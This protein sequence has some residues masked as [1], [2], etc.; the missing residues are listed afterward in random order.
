M[1][2]TKRKLFFASLQESITNCRTFQ[3]LKKTCATHYGAVCAVTLPFARQFISS[4]PGI[5]VDK[6]SLALLPQ[7]AP[8]GHLPVSIVGDGNCF[9]RTLS[10]LAYGHEGCHVE[11]RGRIT[12]EMALN[13]D[14]YLSPDFLSQGSS[15]DG[16]M[17][18]AS[19]QRFAE[20]PFHSLQ[21]A[22]STLEEE[23]FRARELGKYCGMWHMYAAASVLGT[24]IHSIFPNK[25]PSEIRHLTKRTILPKEL[26]YGTSP[27]HTIM[28][29][30][31][32][33]GQSDEYWSPNHFVPLLP[34]HP[35]N[36]EGPSIVRE[37]DE[38]VEDMD[39][40]NTAFTCLEE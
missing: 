13:T 9:P 31:H 22:K 8:D 11:M 12:M 30:S 38:E 10:L 14:Q 20:T 2:D 27:G 17:L 28:W 16:N 40:F 23:L 35:P 1:D 34:L 39:V 32:V 24:P 3:E 26:Q 5:S 21:S 7:D 6:G 4:T 19:L 37:S 25:G 33:E 15:D 18:L 29:T 36:S